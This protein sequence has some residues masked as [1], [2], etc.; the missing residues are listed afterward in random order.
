VARQRNIR[1]TLAYDGGDFFGW[2]VQPGRR[3]VQGVLEQAIAE[4]TGEATRVLS[5]GRTDAGV[6]A[7]GQV[8]NFRTTSTIPPE[9]WRPALQSRLPEDVVILESAAVA[10]DFHATYSAVSKRY[11]YVLRD[12]RLEDPFLRRYVWRVGTPLESE[13]MHA[14]AQPLL[15]R[16][17]FRCFETDW[18]NK[19][20][21]VRTVH[22]V[23][24]RRMAAWP[25]WSPLPFGEPQRSEDSRGEF[26]VFE[27][28]ADGFLYNMVRA[29]V[30]TLVNVGRG[31]WPVDVLQ[32]I[33]ASQ[34]RSR[35][36]ETAPPQ[37]LYLVSVEYGT[38]HGSREEE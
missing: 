18:P 19:A 7:L 3:T 8:A 17:D 9:K 4:L 27:I 5:A 28:A 25:V 38:D 36:G 20:S 10:D 34:D 32:E 33:L 14:A 13:A 2:Q 6:H 21:S 12:S 15:G 16:H 22:E 23:Q 29:I 24:C 30:G 35:A 11:R 31:K 1:L 26:L 37:G